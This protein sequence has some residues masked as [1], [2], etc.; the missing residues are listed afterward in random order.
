MLKKI[1]NIWKKNRN[2]QKIPKIWRFWTKCKNLKSSVV[3]GKDSMRISKIWNL[4]KSQIKFYFLVIT[5]NQSPIENH[6][7]VLKMY[8][9]KKRNYKHILSTSYHF[10][11]I[12]PHPKYIKNIQKNPRKVKIS[13]RKLPNLHLSFRKS[14]KMRGQKSTMVKSNQI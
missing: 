2:D 6:L 11:K 10:S 12:D 7:K 13:F 14:K 8:L 4:W 1:R 3:F 5:P 9:I